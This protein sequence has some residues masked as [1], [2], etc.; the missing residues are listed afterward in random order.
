ME[1]FFALSW[2]ITWF[3]HEIRDTEQAKRLFDVFIVSH[4]LFPLYMA[5][6]MV[7]HPVNRQEILGA[8]C[9]FAV[10]HQVLRG[11]PR[12]SSMVGWKYRPGDGYVSDDEEDDDDDD[13]DDLLTGSNTSGVD[14]DF[15]IIREELLNKQDATAVIEDEPAGAQSSVSTAGGSAAESTARVPF[16]ELIDLAIVIVKKMPPRKLLN[17]SKRYYGAEMVQEYLSQAPHMSL[18][19]DLP[20]WSVAPYADADTALLQ[21]VLNGESLS[22]NTPAGAAADDAVTISRI[23]KEKKC[24]PAVIALGLGIAGTEAARRK[25]RRRRILVA[26]ITIAVVA[27][28]IGVA[29]QQKRQGQQQLGSQPSTTE[30]ST[31]RHLPE[32]ATTANATA[33]AQPLVDLRKPV[34][35]TAPTPAASDYRESMQHSSPYQTKAKPVESGT[36]TILASSPTTSRASV[37]AMARQTSQQMAGNTKTRVT[38]TTTTMSSSPTTPTMLPMTMD[39]GRSSGPRGMSSGD[40]A[41]TMTQQMNH[42]WWEAWRHDDKY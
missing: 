31:V 5:I 17:L 42:M 10:L 13:D 34:A 11:L 30:T 25:R 3:S 28:A 37:Q 16:Q 36:P 7:V 24:S 33:K 35:S 20:T 41:S 15:A 18:F 23:L 9:D 21:R 40:T 27:I 2:L 38:T 4:P 6:A 1:P 39:S 8:E 12:N 26:V 19:D 32:I 14:G 22:S 29:Y